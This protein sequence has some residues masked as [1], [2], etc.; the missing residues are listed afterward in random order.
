MDLLYLYKF[1]FIIY[2]YRNEV[3]PEVVS[4][5]MAAVSFGYGVFQLCIS[6]LPPSLLKLIQLLGFGGDRVSGLEALMFSREGHD[7]RAPL[8]T[9]VYIYIL[10]IILYMYYSIF[11]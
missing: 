5:L 2:C 9:L 1:V 7:M 10:Y 3:P 4:R 6:L 8:A 11:S